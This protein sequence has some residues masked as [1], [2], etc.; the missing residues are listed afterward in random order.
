[1][2]HAWDA[3]EEHGAVPVESD[4]ADMVEVTPA[5]QVFLLMPTYSPG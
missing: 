2:R 5:T 1:M 4:L 3:L